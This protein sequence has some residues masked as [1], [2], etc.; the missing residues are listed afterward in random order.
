MGP[1]R[2]CLCLLVV[3]V[4][5]SGVSLWAQSWQH[6]AV[7][8]SDASGGETLLNVDWVAPGKVARLILIESIDGSRAELRVVEN[9]YGGRLILQERLLNDFRTGSRLYQQSTQPQR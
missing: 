3:L 6:V 4:G 9:I 8:T 1:M 2:K 5:L 7:L